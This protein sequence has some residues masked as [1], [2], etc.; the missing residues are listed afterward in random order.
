MAYYSQLPQVNLNWVDIRDTLGLG[1]ENDG[2]QMMISPNVNPWGFNP[3]DAG[4][5]DR[6]YGVA[7]YSRQA[8]HD[9][10]AFRR[11]EHRYRAY[12]YDKVEN[13]FFAFGIGLK[14]FTK[15]INEAISDDA[16]VGDTVIRLTFTYKNQSG[17]WSNGGSSTGT[18]NKVGSVSIGQSLTA[19]GQYYATQV[20]IKLTSDTPLTNRYFDSRKV[21]ATIGEY[22]VDDFG[23]FEYISNNEWLVGYNRFPDTL[24][25]TYPPGCT[26]INGFF[27]LQ[28]L[29]YA[30]WGA[31]GVGI[32]VDYIEVQ[33]LS[34]WPLDAYWILRVANNPNFTDS[35]N[36]NALSPTPLQRGWTEQGYQTAVMGILFDGIAWVPDTTLYCHLMINVGE[37]YSDRID[38]GDTNLFNV[39]FKMV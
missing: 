37:E 26:E 36:Y 11:Y 7:Y 9:M 17:G 35:S 19:F 21:P 34:P 30:Y 24:S 22:Y 15:I 14:I 25:H 3:P 12:T 5:F 20:K 33:N 8:P 27:N 13:T 38:L 1:A 29:N 39:K 28:N 16:P 18:L 32:Y 2:R 4:Q 31:G 23:L 6:Y 10:G